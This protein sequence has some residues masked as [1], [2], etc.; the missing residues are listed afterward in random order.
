MSDMFHPHIGYDFISEVFS[1]M[2]NADQHVF[3]VLTKRPV[4]AVGWWNECGSEKFGKWPDNVWI[5][6]SVESQ[7]YAP[8]LTV[9][10]R[11]PAAVRFV[12]AEPLLERINLTEWLEDGTLHWVIAGGESGPRAR[13][14]ELDWARELRDQSRVAGVA[15]FL[16]Q[17]GGFRGG[18]RSGDSAV[19]DGRTWRDMPVLE[20]G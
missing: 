6:T 5:G 4:I 3:Q 2:R 8:R 14:M 1:V 18:K 10:G 9:L 17:L 13:P 15:F 16:K 20:H 7:K 12:S 19:I 11:I